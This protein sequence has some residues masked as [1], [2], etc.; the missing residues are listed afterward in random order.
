[1]QFLLAFQLSV[2][3]K[4]IAKFSFKVS[5]SLKETGGP[6]K[7]PLLFTKVYAHLNFLASAEDDTSAATAR[8]RK[9]AQ[10]EDFETEPDPTISADEQTAIVRFK[11]TEKQALRQIKVLTVRF[12]TYGLLGLVMNLPWLLAFANVF[13]D[14]TH[15]LWYPF[16]V[17]HGFQGLVIFLLFDL[18]AKIYYM[19]YEKVMG[20]PHPN[21]R[22]HGLKRASGDIAEKTVQR[23]RQSGSNAS[24]SSSSEI[25]AQEGGNGGVEGCGEKL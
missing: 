12:G 11:E 15:A 8:Q 7:N 3:C 2:C 5:H 1:M 23:N 10:T 20:K 9:L 14:L 24:S 6:F 4:I 16:V 13:S 21:V 19:T 25:E 22:K 17:F 18:K